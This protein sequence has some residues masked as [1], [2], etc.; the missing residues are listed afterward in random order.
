MKVN[1]VLA[2]LLVPAFL[3]LY[4]GGREQN[5][6]CSAAGIILTFGVAIIVIIQKIGGRNSA[7]SGRK[8]GSKEKGKSRA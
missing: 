2:V 7:A 1:N 8:E 3:F 4:C 6:L 5:A